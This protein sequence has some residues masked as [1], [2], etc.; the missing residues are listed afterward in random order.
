MDFL[1]ILLSL[2][3]I[4][5]LSAEISPLVDNIYLNCTYDV[6]RNFEKTIP[7][8]KKVFQIDFQNKGVYQL[9]S[10]LSLTIDEWN[11]YQIRASYD[12]LYNV[13]Y[14]YS[15]NRVSGEFTYYRSDDNKFWYGKGYCSQINKKF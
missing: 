2:L 4:K 9:P 6:N 7:N 1:L 11:D 5:Y 12:S 14:Q 10:K 13:S 15:I 3:G 8:Q